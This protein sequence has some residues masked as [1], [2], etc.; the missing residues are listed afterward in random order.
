MSAPHGERISALER[1]LADHESRCEERLREI[2]AT[3]SATQK[4]VEGLKARALAVTL[5]LLAWAL[6]QVWSTVEFDA[7]PRATFAPVAQS[8]GGAA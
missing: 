1:G 3:A 8:R 2:K 5:A 6:A 4:A 7:A